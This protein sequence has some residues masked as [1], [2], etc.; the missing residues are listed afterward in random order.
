MTDDLPT[1]QLPD[2]RRIVREEGPSWHL[3]T[4]WGT[5]VVLT[6]NAEGEFTVSTVV[7]RDDRVRGAM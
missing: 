6:E 3:V 1:I 2:G 4:P 5:E 7:P